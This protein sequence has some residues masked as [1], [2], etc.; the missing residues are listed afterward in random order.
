MYISIAFA[1]WAAFDFLQAIV[2]MAALLATLPLIWFSQRQV[3][4]V[5]DKELRI[6]KA[7]ISFEYLTNP[8]AVD[9]REYRALRT[10]KYDARSFHAT[11]PWLK[12][13]VKVELNDERDATNYWLIGVKKNSQ[14]IGELISRIN[15]PN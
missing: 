8:I 7:H 13:G 3:I 6:N 11:R 1:V 15:K 4:T 12:E 14:L 9:K 5:D 2:S 10:T